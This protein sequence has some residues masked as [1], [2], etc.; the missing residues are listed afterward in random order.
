[1][2]LNCTIPALVNS[3]VGSLRG[4]SG[5]D[6]TTSWPC[7]WKYARKAARMSLAVCMTKIW[8]FFA[9][10][11]RVR[12]RL[13]P[14]DLWFW[15]GAAQQNKPLAPKAIAGAHDPPLMARAMARAVEA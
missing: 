3:K 8:A 15:P 10:K 2:F 7:R 11:P 14:D 9:R 13:R 12:A 5:L 1:T 4:T 6:G